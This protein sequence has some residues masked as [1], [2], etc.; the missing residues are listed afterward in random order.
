MAKEY[1]WTKELKCHGVEKSIKI[2]NQD[3]LSFQGE[4]DLLVCS[5]YKDHYGAYPGTLIGNLYEKKQISVEEAA[6][7][8]EVDYR[9]QK[10]FW[11]SKELDGEIR[12]VGCIELL[13]I[14]YRDHPEDGHMEILK[15]SFS[16]LY[17]MLE[18]MDIFNIPMQRVVLPVLGTGNQGIEA[19]YV[20]PPLVTQCIRA[21]KNF[22]QLKE[23][24][25]CEKDEI[26][27]EEL[28][29]GLRKVEQEMESVPDLF[30]SYCSAQ[31]ECADS[32]RRM[33]EK[34]GVEVWMAPYSI[35]TG[36]SYQAEIPAALSKIPYVL[37]IL[38]EEAEKSRWVQKEVGCTIGARH[39]LL[40]YKDKSYEHSK[41]FAF[42]L[43][44]EQIYEADETLT[45]DERY[46]LVVQY[47]LERIGKEKQKAAEVPLAKKSVKCKRAANGVTSNKGKELNYNK[48]GVWGI[49]ILILLQLV[50]IISILVTGFSGRD[51]N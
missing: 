34:N 21:L 28:V 36:S 47:L 41:Q 3:I 40:P 46:E 37:L 25:L 20:I 30:I 4:M 27:A 17:E 5:A 1:L 11:I 48:L 15:N 44:G 18:H 19:C 7:E 31:R 39:T 50:T 45:S 23:I 12:R 9:K 8:P 10:N 32:I 2:L 13:D 33:L 24:I 38:S 14:S 35:P 43:D 16:S 6:E 51:K 22:S 29:K 49:G 26:K 42:L